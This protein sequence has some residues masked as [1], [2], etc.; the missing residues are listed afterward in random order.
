MTVFSRLLHGSI[1]VSSYDSI[2]EVNNKGT[3]RS[4]KARRTFY[5]T[6]QS[7]CTS[8]LKPTLGNIHKFVASDEGACIL[9]IIMPPYTDDEGMRP[10][11]YYEYRDC[12]E[13]NDVTLYLTE[14]CDF[15][16]ERLPYA[17]PAIH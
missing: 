11:R 3:V 4:V 16:T 8:M 10:C 17:G 7:P 2:N 5:G 12:S 14:N 13:N 15:W 9:D 6:L 1:E